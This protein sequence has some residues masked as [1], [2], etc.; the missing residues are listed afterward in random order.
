[1]SFFSQVAQ[2]DHKLVI[3][4]YTT[5]DQKIA[6]VF[7]ADYISRHHF[8]YKLLYSGLNWRFVSTWMKAQ[9]TKITRIFPVWHIFHLGWQMPS[10]RSNALV[11]SPFGSES[12]SSAAGPVRSL[13]LILCN[14]FAK[15]W[16]QQHTHL[17]VSWRL[18]M[19]RGLFELLLLITMLPAIS[20]LL[21]CMLCALLAKKRWYGI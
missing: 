3:L 15:T 7:R 12:S 11:K 9:C 19:S 14:D 16:F 18:D 1:V 5:I 6:G 4:T 21:Y 17:C 2:W 10:Q 8:T 13:S 20:W